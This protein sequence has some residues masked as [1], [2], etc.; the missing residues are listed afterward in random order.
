MFVIVIYFE[1]NPTKKPRLCG[2]HYAGNMY[3]II[4]SL[5]IPVVLTFEQSF[6]RPACKNYQRIQSK[7]D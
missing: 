6:E 4:L 1:H 3:Y 5:S 7:G 2:V